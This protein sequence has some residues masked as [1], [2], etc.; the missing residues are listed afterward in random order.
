M[1]K[2]GEKEA[3]QVTE[4]ITLEKALKVVRGGLEAKLFIPN[5]FWVPV[6]EAYDVVQGRLDSFV[7]DAANKDAQ[8]RTANQEITRLNAELGGTKDRL[9]ET[10]NQLGDSR[11]EVESLSE[12]VPDGVEIFSHPDGTVGPVNGASE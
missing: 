10:L 8:L 12:Q 7:K 9:S 1:A 2:T 3:K 4:E 5:H 6:L 11:D